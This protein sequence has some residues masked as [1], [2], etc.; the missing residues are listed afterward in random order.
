MSETRTADLVLAVNEIA[1]N[2]VAH[3]AGCG[4]LTLWADRQSLICDVHDEGHLADPLAGRRRPEPHDAGGRW[5]WIANQLCDLT[6][7]RR[8]PTGTRIRL[9][10]SLD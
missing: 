9:H 1:S 7:L 10:F 8:T 2:S 5:L 3:G 4:T 6:Q